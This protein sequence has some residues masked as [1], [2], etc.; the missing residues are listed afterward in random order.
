[1]STGIHAPFLSQVADELARGHSEISGD[2]KRPDIS[3]QIAQLEARVRNIYQALSGEHAQAISALPGNEWL[4]DNEYIIQ[5]A[6]QQLKAG[7]PPRF[8]RELPLVG[9]GG[10]P[11]NY[12][13]GSPDSCDGRCNR[14]AARHEL[15]GAVHSCLPAQSCT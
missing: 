3:T 10:S 11:W 8:Y 5:E 1:M 12:P 2:L 13:C 4:L 15:A 14:G 7:L 6:L 9:G